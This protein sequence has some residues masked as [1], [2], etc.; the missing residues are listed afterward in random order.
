MVSRLYFFNVSEYLILQFFKLQHWSAQQFYVILEWRFDRKIR[1]FSLTLKAA[2]EFVFFTCLYL[3]E[4][5]KTWQNSKGKRQ[6]PFC[7]Q[8]LLAFEEYLIKA[9]LA[10]MSSVFS[11]L[12]SYTSPQV[13]S[14][15][16]WKH[17]DEEEK[18]AE[19]AVDTLV[20]KLKKKPN[21]LKDLEDALTS[22]NGHTM[23]KCVT[24]PRSLD[25][26]LQVAHRKNLPHVI[27]CKVWRW[28]DL[29]SH[30]ELKALPFCQFPFSAKQSKDVCINP[31]HYE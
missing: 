14:L 30:H 10:K 6:N 4:Q 26:R 16:K 27:Y 25:G 21:A 11:S 19:K 24:I 15:L 20:K 17:P 18:W 29:A 2:E 1:L 31:Y 28:P 23:S 13:K 8:C 22:K 3:E 9:W 5:L 12:L 7:V